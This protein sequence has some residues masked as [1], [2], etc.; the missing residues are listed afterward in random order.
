MDILLIQLLEKYLSY[1]ETVNPDVKDVIQD[2]LTSQVLNEKTE[3]FPF[4]LPLELKTLYAWHDGFPNLT[5]DWYWF[6]EGYDFLPFDEAASRS[7]ILLT[8][9]DEENN[10]IAWKANFFPFATFE[11]CDCL[12]VVCG[13]NFEEEN[14]KIYQFYIEDGIRL[15]YTSF[16]Q[17]ILTFIECWDQDV[18]DVNRSYMYPKNEQLEKLIRLKNNIGSGDQVTL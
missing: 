11:S 17:M 15:A 9:N 3:H 13:D 18:Y 16:K 1:V 5:E 4:S 14:S 8:T 12:F 7:K 6:F 10:Y 2:G